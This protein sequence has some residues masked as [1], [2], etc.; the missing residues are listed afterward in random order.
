[1]SSEIDY[2]A[3]RDDLK[4]RI[5]TLQAGLAAVEAII[6][7][8]AISTSG[9]PRVSGSQDIPED[10]F[11]GMTLGD[12]AVKY[13]GMVRKMQTTAQ[14]AE[15]VKQGGLPHAKANAVYTALT[16]REEKIGDVRV[17]ENNLWGLTEWHPT[18]RRRSRPVSAK[19]PTVSEPSE[20]KAEEK[21]T[22]RHSRSGTMLDECEQLLKAKGRP[23]HASVLVSLL[24]EKFERKTNVKSIAGTLPQDAKKRFKNLGRNVWALA[25]WPEEKLKPELWLRA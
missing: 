4:K 10:A 15:G 1:V 14:I 13:L 9:S 21:P 12:A 2:I 7:A 23:I 17:D 19:P 3:V 6:A 5:E 8:G 24:E 20:T 11:L 25:E 16:R 22:S 18:A